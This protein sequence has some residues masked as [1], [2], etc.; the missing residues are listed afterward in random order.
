MKKYQKKKDSL[1]YGKNADGVKYRTSSTFKGKSFAKQSRQ[2][3]NPSH[4][5][6]QHKG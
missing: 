1:S 5:Q 4:F 3:R 2:F 6:T